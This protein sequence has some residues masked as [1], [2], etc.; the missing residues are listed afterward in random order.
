MAT[1]TITSRIGKTTLVQTI[2]V[3][4]AKAAEPAKKAKRKPAS[5]KPVANDEPSLAE[6]LSGEA[7][8]ESNDGSKGECSLG[9]SGAWK[10]DGRYSESDS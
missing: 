5:K 3:P 9:Q 4:E 1:K 2:E 8:L 7:S 10:R 6:V